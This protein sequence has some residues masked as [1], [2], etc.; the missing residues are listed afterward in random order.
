MVKFYDKNMNEVYLPKDTDLHYGSYPLELNISSIE[1]E[2]QGKNRVPIGRQASLSAFIIASREIDMKLKIKQVY[3]FFRTLGEFYVSDSDTPFE[4]LKVSVDQS[5]DIGFGNGA[6]IDYEIPLTVHKPYF[7]QSLHTTLDIDREGVRWNDKWGYGM[8]LSS[9]R[10]QWKYSFEPNP[11]AVNLDKTMFEQGSMFLSN[12]Q[13]ADGNT[14][15]GRL[16]N[17]YSVIKGQSYRLN[18][19]ETGGTIN[20]IRIFHYD[21]AGNKVGDEGTTNVNGNGSTTHNFTALGSSIRLLIYANGSVQVNVSGIGTLT[22][23]SLSSYS[24]LIHKFRFYNAGTEEIKLIQQK[25]SVIT[26]VALSPTSAIEIFDGEKTFR[27]ERPF[28]IGDR[29]TLK[30]HQIRVNNANVLHHTNRNFLT[31]KKG[32][33]EWEIRGITNFEF[34]IDFR[35][36]YD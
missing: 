9:E 20:Y 1:Y 11:T 8:G 3:E 7:K 32:W 14:Q 18:L 33:N 34:E 10:E 5:Y 15:L 29:L 35:F 22:K 13:N 17:H 19:N 31:I 24:D 2:K 26:L 28:K 6:L 12:G 16:K 27:I 4:L 25:E 36:L 30:G 21:N 23:I